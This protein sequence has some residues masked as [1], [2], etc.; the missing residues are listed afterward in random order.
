QNC[1]KAMKSWGDHPNIE[2]LGNLSCDRLPVFSFRLRDG[3][4]GYVHQQL[5]TRLLSDCYGIQARGG[6]ACAGPYVHRVLDIDEECSNT[7][8]TAIL[9]GQEIEKPGFAR[10]NFSFLATDSEVE[11]IIAAVLELADSA[12]THVAAYTC[13]AETA[14]FQPAHVNGNK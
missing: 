13:D 6:C 3:T 2:L 12:G 1:A 8:R 9:A 7:L 4:G 5:V 11:T 10:L 14:I